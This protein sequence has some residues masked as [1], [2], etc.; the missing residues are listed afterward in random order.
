MTSPLQSGVDPMLALF[1]ERSANTA[2]RLNRGVS[3]A[4][5]DEVLTLPVERAVDIFDQPFLTRGP[6]LLLAMPAERAR[7]VLGNRSYRSFGACL[8]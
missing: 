3:R 8:C 6:T 4:A 1:G 5:V 2:E 7:A